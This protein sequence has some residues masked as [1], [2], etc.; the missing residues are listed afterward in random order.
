M[1]TS[2]D[3]DKLRQFVMP[4]IYKAVCN[5]TGQTSGTHEVEI[6]RLSISKAKKFNLSL[7]SMN[8][9]VS[10][11]LEAEE[12]PQINMSE[13]EAEQ[14]QDIQRRADKARAIQRANEY[15]RDAG[16]VNSD[17]NGKL[18]RDFIENA[19][20]HWTP[21]LVDAAITALNNQLEWRSTEPAPEP[22]KPEVLKPW[23]LPLDTPD[24]KLKQAS[25]EA[26]KDLVARRRLATTGKY[27][28]PR[29]TFGSSL[30]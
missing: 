12:T 3:L 25:V 5:Q 13:L 10:A 9:H 16:L 29:G 23:Q 1:R 8:Q 7:W 18:I 2:I 6:D 17:A 30:F 11:P 19:G 4:D 28:R 15:V 21:E 22:E 26:L 20:G 14:Q 24:W 27:L